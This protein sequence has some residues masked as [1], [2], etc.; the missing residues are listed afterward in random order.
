[1]WRWTLIHSA[2]SSVPIQTHVQNF[3]TYRLKPI[4][5]SSDKTLDVE[6]TSFD[7]LWFRVQVWQWTSL[8]MLTLMTMLSWGIIECEECQAPAVGWNPHYA[9][10]FVCWPSCCWH[11]IITDNGIHS[12]GASAPYTCGQRPEASSLCMWTVERRQYSSSLSSWAIG[13]QIP[14]WLWPVTN[15]VLDA[16]TYTAT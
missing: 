5:P 4:P 7:C 3:F 10:D 14:F 6:N 8:W 1:M 2:L 9:A 15:T 13:H 11:A 16:D 12:A